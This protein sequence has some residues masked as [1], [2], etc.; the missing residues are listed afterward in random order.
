MRAEKRALH[1]ITRPLPSPMTMEAVDSSGAYLLD[2]GRIFVLWLGANVSPAFMSQA[3][4][5]A[6]FF[7][8]L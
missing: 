5:F 7:R 1:R 8:D 3:I 2:S 4:I 6:L